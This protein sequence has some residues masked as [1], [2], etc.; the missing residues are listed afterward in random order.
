[1]KSRVID[2][3]INDYL[4]ERRVSAN[5][6]IITV[7]G[8]L[9]AAHGGGVWLSDFI[10]LVEPLGLNERVVR[11]S[12]YRL[13][14]DDWLV[15]EQ[16][17]RR[18]YYR[19][20]P[21]GLRRADH[22]SRRIYDVR[23]VEW[24]GRWQI[25]ILPATLSVRLRDA[26]RRELSWAGYGAVAPGVLV[27]PSSDSATLM[28][29]LDGTGTRD[30]VV[31]LDA[32]SLDA[33]TGLPLKD[34][35]RECWDLE[36][37]GATYDE[38]IARFRPVLR[39]LSAARSL[40]PEQCFLVQ[41]LLMHEFRRVLL[42]DPQLPAQ[43]TPNKWSGALARNLCQSLYRLT[44]RLAQQHLLALCET[45]SGPLPPP[46]PDFYRRFGGLGDVAGD[47]ADDVAGIAVAP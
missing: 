24:D 36:A 7:Y 26:L 8:D 40:D 39:T 17:G 41:T 37:I 1:M 33:L 27:R 15:S 11:T 16:I 3:W 38:F 43:M 6:L 28:E 31:P 32:R 42:H 13:V 47:V 14:Q 4:S 18:S 22:A 44:Y 34:L 30:K 21:S 19:L 12:V 23:C 45:P 29:I 35:A 46:S 5:S 9:I 20:T 25:V 2:R 10:R